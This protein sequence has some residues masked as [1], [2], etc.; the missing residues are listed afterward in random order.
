MFIDQLHS[1]FCLVVGPTTIVIPFII[2]DYN[3]Y[4]PF[5]ISLANYFVKRLLQIANLCAN[6]L[7]C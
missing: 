3:L 2:Q 7:K 5:E 4:N 1:L 6:V